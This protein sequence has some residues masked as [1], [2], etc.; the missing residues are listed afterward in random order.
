MP[1]GIRDELRYLSGR[2]RCVNSR[3]Q[4]L[5]LREKKASYNAQ[6]NWKAAVEFLH[7]WQWLLGGVLAAAPAVYY[8]PRKALETWD[9]YVER[10]RDEPLL[11][12]MRDRKLVPA[13]HN[14]AIEQQIGLSPP[15]TI[16]MVIVS[17]GTY[18]VGDLSNITKRSRTSIG[19]SMRRL[20][21]QRKIELDRGGFRLVQP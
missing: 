8:G 6:V 13:E 9:W 5:L 14:M 11:Q 18:S 17:E 4:T 3:N 1:L 12:I 19:K 2:R 7:R 16:N 10:C 15:R 20:R 21:A